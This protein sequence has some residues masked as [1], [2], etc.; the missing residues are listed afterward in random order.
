MKKNSEDILHF[1]VF[2]PLDSFWTKKDQIPISLPLPTVL[3]IW[4]EMAVKTFG[5]TSIRTHLCICASHTMMQ[6]QLTLSHSECERQH[7][8]DGRI[9]FHGPQSYFKCITKIECRQIRTRKKKL[10]FE[11]DCHFDLCWRNKRISGK[12]R[13]TFQWK[14]KIVSATVFQQG[15][16]LNPTSAEMIHDWAHSWT[17]FVNIC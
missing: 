10:N 14:V 9:Q 5:P 6:G 3:W 8:N 4:D 1:T 2:S 7:S 15:I 13:H 16:L 12:F 17:H 11:T